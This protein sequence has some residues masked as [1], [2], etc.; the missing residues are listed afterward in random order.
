MDQRLRRLITLGREHYQA[1]EL[2]KAEACLSQVVAEHRGFADIFNMLGVIYHEKGRFKQAAE[3]L[4]EALKINPS[5]TEAA[6]NLAVAYNELGKY[7]QAREV[8]NR[9]IALSQSE[10]RSLDPFA[11]G[12]LANMHAD[13]GAAYAGLG[14]NVEAVREYQKAL[15]LGPQFADLRTRLAQVYRDM[16]DKEAALREL[17]SVKESHPR[18]VPARLA[19]GHALLALGRREE[20]VLEWEAALEIDPAEKRA[21]VY[22]QMVKPGRIDPGQ[23]ELKGDSGDERA[24]S[25]DAGLED[26]KI[27]E[28]FESLGEK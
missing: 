21:Q 8:Y 9:A 22:L 10:P 19:L 28:I 3:A 25:P 5:Y 11:R 24:P 16:G 14:L 17:L 12:K 13:L 4:E 26:A 27:D 6:L 1:H 2:D 18:F 7:T 15:E 20:A 23:N